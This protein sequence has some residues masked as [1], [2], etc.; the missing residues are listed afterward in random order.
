MTTPQDA[1]RQCMDAL[2]YTSIAIRHVD[3]GY[4]ASPLCTSAR[5][6]RK[7]AIAIAAAEAS[8]ASQPERPVALAASAAVLSDKQIIAIRK[9]D[10]FKPSATKPWQ[11]SID[12]AR[13]IL[14]AAS[15]KGEQP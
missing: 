10:R 7:A 3:P 12:F 14:A 8:L 11:D 6:M 9:G 1:L 2:E 15:P 4:S 13:A 5:A